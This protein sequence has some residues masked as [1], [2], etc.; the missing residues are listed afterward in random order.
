LKKSDCEKYIYLYAGAGNS[1]QTGDTGDFISWPNIAGITNPISKFN[2]LNASASSGPTSLYEEY[3]QNDG[4]GLIYTGQ[5]FN[6]NTSDE[7]SSTVNLSNYGDYGDC[8]LQSLSLQCT[9]G[10]LPVVNMDFLYSISN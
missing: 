7:N 2:V 5:P 10:Q 6:I 3:T 8:L 1:Y 4:Y 9:P